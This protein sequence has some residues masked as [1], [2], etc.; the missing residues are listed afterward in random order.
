MST[1]L[2]QSFGKHIDK[3]RKDRKLSIQKLADACDMDKAQIQKVCNGTTDPRMST[4]IKLATGLEVSEKEL[5]DFK[6]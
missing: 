3:L 5:F 2:I 4:L 1:K 6:R